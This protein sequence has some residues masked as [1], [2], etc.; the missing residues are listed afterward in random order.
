[1]LTN[2]SVQCARIHI[3]EK[4]RKHRGHPHTVTPKST[5]LMLGVFSMSRYEEALQKL[6]SSIIDARVKFWNKVIH[7]NEQSSCITIEKKPNKK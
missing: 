1:M 3:E 7:G 2:G 6:E 4:K 5:Y